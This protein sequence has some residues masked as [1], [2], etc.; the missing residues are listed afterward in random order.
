MDK[1][2][3]IYFRQ[4]LLEEKAR[5]QAEL[6]RMTQDIQDNARDQFQEGALE[7]DVASDVFEQECM[8]AQQDMLRYSLREIDRALERMNQGTYGYSDLS[9]LPIPIERLEALPWASHLVT[10]EPRRPRKLVKV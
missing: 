7:Q 3:L 10:E 6:D 1:E 4:R 2:Q 5:L 9:G 8:L